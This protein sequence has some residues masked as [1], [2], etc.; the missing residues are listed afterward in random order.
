LEAYD[1]ADRRLGAW[2]RLDSPPGAQ[3][4]QGR[5]MAKQSFFGEAF[6]LAAI[7]VALPE[8]QIGLAKE[9]LSG[10]SR[11][12]IRALLQQS[13]ADPAQ[14]EWTRE[15]SYRHANGFLKLTIAEARGVRLRMHIWPTAQTWNGNIHN[16]RWNFAS[17]ILT[18]T[19]EDSRFT[20]TEPGRGSIAARYCRDVE[21][22]EDLTRFREVGVKLDSRMLHREGSTYTMNS[23]SFHMISGSYSRSDE[24]VSLVIT[25]APV[26][27][28][29]LVVGLGGERPLR[30]VNHGKLT[31]LEV[32]AQLV[33]VADAI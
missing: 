8:A 22:V 12:S 7:A 16:H 3:R 10:A 2:S 31:N 21:N 28:D 30:D 15:R 27:P 13:A 20:V 9:F 11:G 4:P 24:I 29:S 26:R 17:R 18:G 19:M 23:D 33:S 25:C 1:D 14:V 32:G 5:V 6:P